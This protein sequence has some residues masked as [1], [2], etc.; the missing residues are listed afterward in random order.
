[1]DDFE[2]I[3]S[4][5]TPGSDL[6]TGEPTERFEA[7]FSRAG[8]DTLYVDDPGIT[9]SLSQNIDFLFGDLFD[10]SEE[11]FEIVTNIQ[12]TQQGGNPLLI[13]DRNIPSVGRDR[14]ILGDDSKP[15]YSASDPNT[16]RTTNLLGFNEF[17]VIYDFSKA[18]DI[19]QLNGRKE[20]YRVVEVNGL[21]VEG[22]SQPFF[23]EVI[24]S[25][26]QGT[27]D[28]VAYVINRPEDDININEKYFEFAG[29]KPPRKPAQRR[30]GQLGTTEID[31]SVGAAADSSGNVYITGATNGP[32]G[33][34][35]QGGSDAWV[36]K[37]DSG[38]NQVFL[39]QFGSSGAEGANAVVTDSAGNFYLVGN[40]S[41]N[42]FSGKQSPGS[43][44]WVA[45]Y[46]SNANLIWSRQFS[47]PGDLVL[48]NGAFG[49]DVDE[50]GNVYVSGLAIKDNPNNPVFDFNVQDDSWVTKFDANGNQQWFNE[51]GSF[52]F[53]ECY[54]LTV[55]ANGNTYAVGW[56]QGLIGQGGQESDPSRQLLKYDAWIAKWDTNG[57]RQWVQ[58]LGSVNQG[59]EFGWGVDTDSQGNAYVTGWTTGEVGTRD[60][61]STKAQGYDVFLS[62]FNPDGTQLFAKQFGS[63]GDDAMVLSDM[64]IDAQDNIFLTG[65]TNDKLGKGQSDRNYSAWVGRFD[66]EGN[67]RWVQQFGSKRKLDYATA[68]SADD[69]GRLYVTGFTE[70]LLGSGTTGSAVDAWL[71]QLDVERGR[72]QRFIG[73]PPKDVGS[74][75]DPG[76]IGTVNLGSD[77]VP[78]EQL[79]AGDN[80]I[81][82]VPGGGRFDPERI[83]SNLGSLFGRDSQNS[84]S[85]VFSN[86]VANNNA[87][88]LNPDDL[89]SLNS[90]LTS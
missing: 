71:A 41:G 77:L 88:F 54:D 18:Q 43:D 9:G 13:L 27:P 19:I 68:L 47:A 30:I 63:P 62:K 52:F 64:E 16:L 24:F 53:D 48:S 73:E 32:L 10:N 22:I 4:L 66:T 5:L 58:Q 26:Q 90:A 74:I 34:P 39:R 76:A 7:I 33:G 86:G 15:Y 50:T 42:L 56:T 21:Q 75:A 80:R 81:D 36:S 60:R 25:L 35:R 12:N 45:K 87:P 72:V 61:R 44:A 85:N 23:G 65:Y 69:N 82:A 28:A 1:M 2:L 3:V 55:D 67:N 57:Q 59:L 38:G 51:L 83:Q 8:N 29:T 20:D 11:E 89:S 84:F 37:Y 40:T 79:P 78:D 70:G 31:T 17:A 49:L 46:D 6:A 14:F